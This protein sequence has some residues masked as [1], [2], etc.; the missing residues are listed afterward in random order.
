MAANE[1]PLTG[2]EKTGIEA[3]CEGRHDPKLDGP[4]YDVAADMDEDGLVTFRPAT[5]WEQVERIYAEYLWSQIDGAVGEI[6]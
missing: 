2:L 5:P 1:Y 4:A 3:I 6:E